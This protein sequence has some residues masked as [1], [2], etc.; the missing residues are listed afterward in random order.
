MLTVGKN[1]NVNKVIWKLT[2]NGILHIEVL[3]EFLNL[4]LNLFKNIVP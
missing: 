4:S 1:T 3:F 2:L